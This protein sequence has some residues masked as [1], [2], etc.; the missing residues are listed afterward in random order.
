MMRAFKLSVA[1]LLAA[2]LLS[3]CYFHDRDRDDHRD[4]RSNSSQQ[5]QQKGAY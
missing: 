5:Q 4:R 1:L 3:G 2:C